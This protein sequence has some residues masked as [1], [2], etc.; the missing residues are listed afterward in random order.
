MKKRMTVALLVLCLLLTGLT[1][2]AS[3]DQEA[4]SSAE[5]LTSYLFYDCAYMLA[6][7]IE[8]YYTEALDDLFKDDFPWKMLYSSGMI[9]MDV[10][11]NST[12]RKVTI[13]NIEYYPGVKA[14]QAWELEMIHLLDEAERAMLARAETM[15]EE[16]CRY[17][18][19][20]YQVLVNL[21]DALAEEVVY[22]LAEDQEDGWVAEDTALGAL[23]YGKAECDGYA[24][25]FYLL[26]TLA[27]FPA[28]MIS[29]YADNGSGEG[30][31]SHMWNLIWWENGWYHADVAWDDLDWADD[32]TMVNYAYLL[33]GSAMIS[34][35]RWEADHLVC[36]PQSY[37]DWASYYYTCDNTGITYGAYFGTLK[38]AAD[39]AAYMKRNYDRKKIHIMIDG[40][41]DQ[42]YDLIHEALSNSGIGRRTIWTD[43][44]G[45]ADYT[46]I[47]ICI[48]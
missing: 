21:H 20:P 28:R 35:H 36:Q 32:L 47:A 29:G 8:F 25:A 3:T 15:V 17:A 24:D 42:Q 22:T 6:D 26:C 30:F 10:T 11:V 43:P 34:N 2:P 5:E 4:F 9:D 23:L 33:M 27:G 38:D 46:L 14:A 41:Y 45:N 13:R 39:Y 40:D 19:S 16:A 44:C 48:Q 12:K 1:V 31:D 18:Q 7:E 37:A